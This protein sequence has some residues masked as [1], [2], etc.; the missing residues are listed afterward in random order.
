[1]LI[2]A[3]YLAYWLVGFLLVVPKVLPVVWHRLIGL[4]HGVGAAVTAG[5]AAQATLG[6]VQIFLLL[7]PWVGSVL[8]LGMML[9]RPVQWLWG[10]LGLNRPRVQVGRA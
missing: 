10:R 7:L 8:L 5:H 3:P 2:V 1:V 6:A 4:S 9:R